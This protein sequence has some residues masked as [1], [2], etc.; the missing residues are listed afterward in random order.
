MR[1]TRLKNQKSIKVMS[2]DHRS[3]NPHIHSFKAAS[4]DR[5]NTFHPDLLFLAG[6]P[7]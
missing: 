3:R 7:S 6:T 5:R 1:A 4:I 2:E